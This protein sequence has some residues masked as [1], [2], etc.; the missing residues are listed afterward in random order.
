MSEGKSESD[1]LKYSHAKRPPTEIEQLALLDVVTHAILTVRNCVSMMTVEHISQLMDAV[2][3]IPI[4]LQSRT[5][6]G[7]ETILWDLQ[8]FDSRGNDMPYGGKLIE[9]YQASY[10]RHAESIERKPNDGCSAAV[11]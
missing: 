11:S 2:H 7:W 6:D 3:N 10:R 8:N 5:L 9:C 1:I 4:Y